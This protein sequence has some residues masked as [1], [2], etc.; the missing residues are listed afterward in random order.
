MKIK[1]ITKH[2]NGLPIKENTDMQ[3]SYDK[4]YLFIEEIKYKGIKTVP[5]NTFKIKLENIIDTIVASEAEIIE[6]DKS[7]IGRGAIGMIAFGPVGALL[8]G[9][10]GIGKKNKKS[11]S[12]YYVISYV[13]SD[14]E[15]KNVTFD[16]N[17]K[18]ILSTARGFETKLN[19]ILKKMGKNQKIK[20]ELQ[21]ELNIEL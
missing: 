21:E 16:I 14:K 7:V 6:K 12:Y 3:I 9:M 10:S 20:E 15:I 2:V 13:S 4:E 19:K 17:G 8:G 18:M 11:N 1:L 5:I